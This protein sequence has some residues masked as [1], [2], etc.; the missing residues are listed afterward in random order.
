MATLGSVANRLVS[1]YWSLTDETTRWFQEDRLEYNI[2]GYRVGNQVDRNGL[3]PAHQTQVQNVMSYYDTLFEGITFQQTTSSNVRTTD[4]FFGDSRGSAEASTLPRLKGDSVLYAFTNVPR[5][6]SQTLDKEPGRGATLSDYDMYH[7]QTFLHE[8]LHVL[9]LGDTHVAGRPGARLDN[10]SWH[11]SIMSYVDQLQNAAHAD[12]ASRL[13]LLTPRQADFLALERHYDLSGAFDGP[14]VYG[15]TA[16]NGDLPWPLDNMATLLSEAAFTIYDAGGRDHLKF[17]YALPYQQRIDLT[18]VRGTMADTHASDIAG[19]RGNL[20]LAV[21]TVIEHATGGAGRDTIIGNRVANRLVGNAGDDAL[22]GKSGNDRLLGGDGSD[23]LRGGPG[24]DTLVGGA[25][26]DFLFG[27]IGDDRLVGQRGDD[28]LLGSN[29]DDTLFGNHG[30][31]T[32]VGGFGDDRVIGGR[33][34]DSMFG[35]L[36]DFLLKG[37]L[38]RAEIRQRSGDDWMDGGGGND[39]IDGGAGDDTLIGG[40]GD[41]SL[42][43]GLGADCLVGGIGDDWIEGG[44]GADVLF[45]GS[46]DDALDGG[47]NADTLYAGEGNDVLRGGLGPDTIYLGEG[48]D[49]VVLGLAGI[50]VVYGFVNGEDRLDLTDVDADPQSDKFEEFTFIGRSEIIRIGQLAYRIDLGDPQTG[51]PVVTIVGNTDRDPSTAEVEVRL[52]GLD[53]FDEDAFIFA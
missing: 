40:R 11:V 46:G 4:L 5:N 2:T 50:D 24:D 28:S 17:D 45:G 8:I 12:G 52:I 38:S 48:I 6:F 49:R 7:Y 1:G 33:Q 10:D 30:D 21:G 22:F 23:T 39:T 29:G 26:R 41:D 19:Q 53:T 31:D 14:T 43:G 42:I 18:I 47:R 36:Q 34:D 37:K 27:G 44:T 20:T 35:D 15:R 16:S 9:G 3:L 25:D 32:L 13:Y 51:G